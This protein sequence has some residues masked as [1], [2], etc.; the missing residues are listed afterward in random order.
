MRT[1]WALLALA[2]IGPPTLAGELG[3]MEAAEFLGPTLAVH[4]VDVGQG[5][6]ILVQTPAGK[7]ILVDSGPDPEAKK[8]LR[9]MEGLAVD[10]ID[11]AVNTH[12]HSDHIAG[13]PAVLRKMKVGTVLDPG[14]A[15]TSGVYE[16]MVGALEKAGVKVRVARRGRRIRVE[17]EVELEVLGPEDP[18]IEGSRSDLNSNSVVLRL[19]YRD[20]SFLLTG[21]SE[22]D[23]ETRLLREPGSLRSTVL[24]VA[25]HGS[26]YAT[27]DAFIDKVRPRLAVIS[28]ARRNKYGHPAPETVE[29]LR[30]R[31]IP[32]RVTARH[33]TVVVATDGRKLNL[34][35]VRAAT[36]PAAPTAPPLPVA[37][38]GAGALGTSPDAS[39]DGGRIDLNTATVTELVTLPGIGPK[40]AERIVEFRARRGP[41][42]AVEGLRE[43]KGIGPAKLDGLRGRVR[44][45][46]TPVQSTAAQA[47]AAAQ[48]LNE[49]SAARKADRKARAART[50][51]RATEAARAMN[52]KAADRLL[53]LNTAT[54]A[55]LDDLPGIGPALA[56]R[57]ISWRAEHGGFRTVDQLTEVAGIG[58]GK[59]EGVR[60]LV[61]VGQPGDR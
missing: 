52:R 54:A 9:Y 51:T 18:L 19:R 4:F 11:L 16:R 33:G 21:D 5:D 2:L 35:T 8:L 13:L 55:Q 23:T 1:G 60:A 3:D 43:V 26:A 30:R 15:H 34:R 32:V 12:A 41:F 10:S 50:A 31:G 49:R 24:K 25:H 17:E 7:H 61:T 59:L 28:C 38:A 45:G 44:A 20:V 58:A 46:S 40:T 57:I 36:A 29:R 27:H 56:Q 6:A 48:R 53:D 37:V 14:L 39:P 22:E 47:A 42:K